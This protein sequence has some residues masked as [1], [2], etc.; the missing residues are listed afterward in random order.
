MKITKNDLKEMK[1]IYL[2]VEEFRAEY[3]SMITELMDDML[4]LFFWHITN[5]ITRRDYIGD[6]M[7]VD[8]FFG[9]YDLDTAY[10]LLVKEECKYELYKDE[11]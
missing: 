6:N 9:D 11:G 7:L 1:D 10:D 5:K 2:K 8:F 3:E 4:T